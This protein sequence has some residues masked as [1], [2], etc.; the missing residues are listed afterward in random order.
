MDSWIL[1][2]AGYLHAKAYFSH[3]GHSRPFLGLALVILYGLGMGD[4][5]FVRLDRGVGLRF[6]LRLDWVYIGIKT[7]WMM[8]WVSWMIESRVMSGQLEWD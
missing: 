5:F 8:S 4:F 6:G 7:G 2:P 1:E 3:F